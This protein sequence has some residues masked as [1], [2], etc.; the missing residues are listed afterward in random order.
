MVH[1]HAPIEEAPYKLFTNE[2]SL[3]HMKSHTHLNHGWDSVVTVKQRIDYS[4]AVLTY[5][6]RQSGSLSY[7]AA[8]ISD[9][10]PSSSLRS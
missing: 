4:L 8:L 1:Q 6:A 2:H 7:L 3:M 10:A 5:K 9:Y